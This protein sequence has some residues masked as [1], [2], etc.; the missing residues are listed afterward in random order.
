[1][2][3]SKI[4]E[5]KKK[6]EL[7]KKMRTNITEN[8]RT[9]SKELTKLILPLEDKIKF[10]YREIKNQEKNKLK[11][12]QKI[13]LAKL[14]QEWI[15][16]RT[17]SRQKLCKKYNISYYTVQKYI[18]HQ[19]YLR[20]KKQVMLCE[21]KKS[22]RVNSL[23]LSFRTENCLKSKGIYC[24]SDLV[25]KTESDL[26]RITSFGRKSLNEIKDILGMSN[27]NLKKEYKLKQLWR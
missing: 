27:F 19:N 8:Y 15:L 22:D 1:M 16:D 20:Q 18:Y 24:I 6:L 4:T 21:L 26:L 11:A 23:G 5:D 9:Q 7:L 2:N 14:Y 17:Q 10:Y 13:V 12:E 3:L 25:K